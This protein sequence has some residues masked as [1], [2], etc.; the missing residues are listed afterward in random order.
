MTQRAKRRYQRRKKDEKRE[1]RE[2]ERSLQLIARAAL[3]SSAISLPSEALLHAIERINNEALDNLFSIVQS[4]PNEALDS[5]IRIPRRT[6]RE[7]VS[8]DENGRSVETSDSFEFTYAVV[9]NL[10]HWE[11]DRRA[12]TA[13][14]SGNGWGVVFRLRSINFQR[15]DY[16][17]DFLDSGLERRHYVRNSTIRALLQLELF[18]RGALDDNFNLWVINH[19]DRIPIFGE[20]TCC[21]ETN[22][23][24]Y[25]SSQSS[26]CS[27]IDIEL[28]AVDWRTQNE[29]IIF[30]V[31]PTSLRRNSYSDTETLFSSYFSGGRVGNFFS[32]LKPDRR[33]PTC[34]G[35]IYYHQPAYIGDDL[36]CAVHPT[37]YDG[38]RCPDWSN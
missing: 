8:R 3:S 20:V 29:V 34:K 30:T 17:D 6:V 9:D 1:Q 38:D 31:L 24:Y 7:P 25:H 21:S 19:N 4:I 10:Q 36:I 5:L 11:V 16:F 32:P 27:I 12:Y 22:G 2:Y 26:S 33:P 37:G 28:A 23:H 14:V 18:D 13:Q 15:T 35:C